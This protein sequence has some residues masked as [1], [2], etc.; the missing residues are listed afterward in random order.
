[1][2]NRSLSI[3]FLLGFFA[4]ILFYLAL[5]GGILYVAIHFISKFW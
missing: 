2:R 5:V 1:M 3:P 4:P